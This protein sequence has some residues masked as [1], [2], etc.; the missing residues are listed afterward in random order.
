MSRVILAGNPNTGKSLLFSRLTKTGAISANYAGTTAELKTGRFIAAGREYELVDGPGLYGLD[1]ESESD[2]AAIGVLGQ[3]DILL[4]VV[5]ATNLERNLG[6]TLQL[7]AL[8]KPT[9][10]CLNLWDDTRHKGIHIDSEALAGLLGVP[11]ITVSALSGEGVNE[12]VAALPSA[13]PAPELPKGQ[14]EGERWERIGAIIA[15]VQRL[16]HRHHS[17]LERLSDF[18]LNPIGGVLTAIVVL[19]STLLFV[20]FLGEW[21]VSDVLSPLYTK[22]WA[23]LVGNVVNRIPWPFLRGLLAGY[24][25]DPLQSFGV[26]TSGVYIAFV[27]VF[28]YF[29]AFYLV[30][31][32]L[33]D[34]GYLP[35]LAV[36]LDR[37]FHRLGLHGYS[38]IPVMLG[39]G[40]KVPAFLSARMLT[41]RREKILTIT[42]IFMSAPCLPQTSMII[43]YGM[44]Y[45]V[46]TVLAV[47]AVLLALAFA[48]NFALNRVWKGE[49]TDFFAEIPAYRVPRFSLM[50]GKLWMR[51]REYLGEVIPMIAVG[52]LAMNILEITGAIGWITK[53][54]EGPISF[55]FGLPAE[56]APIMLLG[57]LRKDVSI[58]LLAP[59]ALSGRQFLVASV[60]LSLYTPCISAFFTLLRE[61]GAK[62]GL[63]IVLLVFLS[64]A[65]TAAMLHAALG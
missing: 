24:G 44:N 5:D 17:F 35:R 6:L 37:T 41:D 18:T 30:F 40:C 34:S 56:L 43:A 65:V 61:T 31:G 3:A 8:G 49:K 7:L 22:A 1:G 64:A 11:V 25:G 28:P 52:V 4:D 26:L 36:V 51:V 39:L 33:E 58:A 53:A 23:P 47:F 55:L 63:R 12:L 46:G 21:L 20:R 50:A 10:V 54:I 59:L 60:F 48:V 19:V 29:V 27:Q 14:G 13:R 42:L 57:F 16:E 38:S 45:G 15:K 32:F 2:R 9:I 62:T